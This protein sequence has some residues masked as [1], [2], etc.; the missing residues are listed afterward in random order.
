MFD[1]KTL[2]TVLL[3][4][5]ILFLLIVVLREIY[6]FYTLVKEPEE[7]YN[8][9][10][11]EE[12]SKG[13]AIPSPEEFLGQ[14]YNN[15]RRKI[16]E[17]LAAGNNSYLPEFPGE[18]YL[19]TLTLVLAEVEDKG[20]IVKTEKNAVD[21]RIYR[22]TFSVREGTKRLQGVPGPGVDEPIERK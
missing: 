17:L 7:E 10:L 16:A 18:L 6:S 8:G 13:I 5:L 4:L 2:L 22:V 9:D 11:E 15:L 20:Y 3:I 21:G 1:Q 19:H 14:Y 12:P